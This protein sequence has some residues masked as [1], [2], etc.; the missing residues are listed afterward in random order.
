MRPQT[1]L[2]LQQLDLLPA[3]EWNVLAPAWSL[4]R[5]SEGVG[6]CLGRKLAVGLSVG[7][8]VV[9]PP[10]CPVT[11]RASQLGQA[12]LHY[13]HFEPHH[14][15]CLLTLSEQQR[16]A[17]MAE[18]P[19]EQILH[20]PSSH[21]V[22]QQFGA[23]CLTFA[24][25]NRLLE[26]CQM[27]ALIA[28]LFGPKLKPIPQ[29]EEKQ[30]V[31]LRR[32]NEII[33]CLP[34][35]ELLER[36]PE[37]LARQCGCSPRH[38]TRLFRAQFGLSLKARQTQL[39][40]EKARQLLWETDAKVINVALD[41]GYRHLGL[42]NAMFKKHFGLTP[43]EL[44]RSRDKRPPPRTLRALPLAI[45]FAALLFL[46][47]GKALAAE[48]SS[49]NGPVFA[50][51]GYNVEGNTLLTGEELKKLFE[52]YTGAAVNFNTIRQALAALQLA[53]RGRGYITVGVALPQQQLT[54]GV[55][56]VQVTE[57]KLLE[58]QIVNNRYFSSNNIIAAL[59]SL[60]TNMLLNSLVFQ[61]EL[62]HANLNRD[63]QIYP[64][65]E[66]GPE[67]G[68]T[69]LHLKVKDRLPLHTRLEVNNY[70]TPKTPE[71][72]VNAASQYNNLWQL[73]HQVGLQYSFTPQDYKEGDVRPAF[74]NH[75][76]IANYSLFYRLPMN[77]FGDQS[78]RREV[79]IS[80]FGYDEVTKRFRPPTLSGNQEIIFY[81]SRSDSDTGKQIQSEERTPKVIPPEGGLQLHDIVYSQTLSVNDDIGFR[82]SSPYTDEWGI[83]ST[84][85][86]GLDFKYFKTAILQT[87]AFTATI[88]IPINETGHPFETITPSNSPPPSTQGTFES[89]S[90]LPISFSWEASKA[91][92]W[93]VTSFN[94]N[95]SLNFARL[96]GNENDFRT[97]AH[98]TNANGN[99]YIANLGLSREQKLFG[100]WSLRLS[101]DGQW[102]SQTLINNEQ[103]GIGG[104]AGV[105]GYRDGQ[106]YGDRG[107]RVLIEP[108]SELLN[109]GM[110]DGTLP[111]LVRLSLFTDY[112]RRY[113]I[114]PPPGTKQ[115]LSLWGA[116]V[117]VSGTIGERYDF[118]FGLGWP[119]LD[120]PGRKAGDLRVTV[121][122]GLQF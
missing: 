103:F 60:Q 6:Y 35:A 68:T 61:Q 39:K 23:L 9:V 5:V 120:T 86:A 27:L 53:Y 4:V 66:P 62:D 76:L 119:L 43:T 82:W 34:E 15:N 47:A 51:T 64:E 111:M 59:P 105:R 40:L 52:D 18:S 73:D 101:A 67:P 71:L 24:S 33:G 85:S 77:P 115:A 91:D 75:P 55:V 102:A 108:H 44:R 28:T 37:D 48:A 92:K 114:E 94:I 11:F 58:I 16:L 81:A 46:F 87:R 29:P 63:R 10:N 21:T 122:A 8:V 97:V 109:I 26:R 96:L 99:Y 113:L 100:D 80:D 17:V 69:V 74:F 89:V 12:R 19:T 112:G 3:A 107:W 72:R 31:A 50:V 56:K 98:F 79:P 78:Q 117:A 25:E 110:V 42:F 90:Y 118:R 84:F 65:I 13:F 106:E 54:N 57:G 38:F 93:G 7:E 1:P 104:N 30:A 36:R 70:S 88:Y 95:N 45:L 2:T 32:F 14:F 22:A 20:L 41:S 49:T 121:S 83:N 116:G